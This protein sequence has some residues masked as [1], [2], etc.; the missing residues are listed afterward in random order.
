MAEPHYA[1]VLTPITYNRKSGIAIVCAITSHARSWPFEVS[2]PEGLLPPKRG[3][4]AAKSVVLADA[5]RQVDFRERSMAFVAKAPRVVLDEVMD[6]LLAA[7][8]GE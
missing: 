3:V 8:E 6:K 5:V 4:G 1:L 2:M 7:L